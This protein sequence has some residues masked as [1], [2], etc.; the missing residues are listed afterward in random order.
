MRA[1]ENKNQQL[2]STTNKRNN[3]IFP[4]IYFK[5]F[6]SDVLMLLGSEV[7]VELKFIASQR[8]N[9]AFGLVSPSEL[10]TN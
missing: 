9:S 10:V 8:D 1:V 4:L 7:K 3:K 5:Y 2:N 6:I